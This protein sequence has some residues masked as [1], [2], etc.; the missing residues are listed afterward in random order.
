MPAHDHIPL[1]DLT[2]LNGPRTRAE[3]IARTLRMA[4]EMTPSDGATLVLGTGRHW[5]RWTHAAG[6]TEPTP[7]QPWW[8]TPFERTLLRSRQAHVLPDLEALPHVQGTASP[9]IV[10]G[11]ALFLPFR[12]QDGTSGYL[13]VQR[14]AGRVEFGDHEVRALSLLAAW[15]AVS[16]D[17]LRVSADL[18]RLAISDDLTGVHNYRY[19]KTALRR[20]LKRAERYGQ[21]LSVLMV[22]VDHLK[23]YNDRHGHLRGSALLRD[24]AQALAAR[25][26][27]WDLVAKYGGDEFTVILPQT[28]AAEGLVVAERLRATVETHAFALCEPGTI[29]VSIGLASAPAD[30][31]TVQ[32]LLEASDR[33]LY[34]AKRQG[35]N[36][37]EAGERLA[38]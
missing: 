35:R 1:H 19:L 24:L 36:R 33:A 26:R 38:A 28:T 16:L 20:E 23:A 29:T 27:S 4:T 37:V 13:S 17:H 5:E 8:P 14:V 12:L 21:P 32:G 30:A 15:C 22:D 6:G 10:P 3:A 7:P 25:V 34:R 9:G 11:P 18:Q 2:G 31:V